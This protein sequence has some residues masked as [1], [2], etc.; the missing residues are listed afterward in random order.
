MILIVWH[1]SNTVTV[2]ATKADT[3]A[4]IHVHAVGNDP[5]IITATLA[6]MTKICI[7][8]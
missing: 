6:A 7:A 2:T 1:L 4:A 8:I 3:G 5:C